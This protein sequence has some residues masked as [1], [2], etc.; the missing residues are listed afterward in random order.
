MMNRKNIA[1]L[2]FSTSLFSLPI[3][4]VTVYECVDAQNNSVFMDR[5]PPGTTQLT[6]KEFSAGRK[7]EG[8]DL[9]ALATGTPIT[10]YSVPDCDACDLV[11]IY[12]DNRGFPYTENNVVDS[13]ELQD[14]LKEKSGALTVPVVTIGDATVKGYNKPVMDST[15]TKAGYPSSDD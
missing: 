5:C 6:K 7:A 15:L 11:R 3:Q 8:P 13:I 10:F 2:L 4:A 9:R 12:L 1:T 14:E